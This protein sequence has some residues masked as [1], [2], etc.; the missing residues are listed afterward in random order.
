MDED[1]KRKNITLNT[2]DEKLSVIYKNQFVLN[3]K[4][5]WIIH[6]LRTTNDVADNLVADFIYTNMFG[7]I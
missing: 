1:K 4:L 3:Y 2:I 5:D 6:H 7:V